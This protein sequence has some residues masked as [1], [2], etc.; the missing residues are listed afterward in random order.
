VSF[1]GDAPRRTG[2]PV[3]RPAPVMDRV[4]ASDGAHFQHAKLEVM[5]M[6]MMKLAKWEDLTQEERDLNAIGKALEENVIAVMKAATRI[7]R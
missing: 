7:P 5:A 3:S 6:S 1:D 2:K 4:K